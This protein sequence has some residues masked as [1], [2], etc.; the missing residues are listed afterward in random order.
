[1]APLTVVAAYSAVFH[2]VFRV[3]GIDDYPL[4]L[5]S[6]MVAWLFFAAGLQGA[7]ESITA[8]ANLVRKVRFPR[9]LIPLAAVA[10]HAV[11]ALVIVVVLVPLNLIIVPD[12]RSPAMVMLPVGLA[13]LGVMTYGIGL[14]AAALNVYFRDVQHILAALLLPWFFLTPIFYTPDALPPGAEGFRWLTVALE[15]VNFVAPFVIVVRDSVFFGR[16]P[17]LGH[18]GYCAGVAALFLVAGTWLFRRLDGEM[19]VEL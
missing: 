5:L 18:L 16:W 4:F 8:N 13:L 9:Q 14:A 17:S 2:Y 19:A 3:V 12:S 1:M 11:T 15:W 7:S 6:G 10:G